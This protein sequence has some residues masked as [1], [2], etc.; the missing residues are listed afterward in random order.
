MSVL[1]TEAK[2]ASLQEALQ[3]GTVL[4]ASTGGGRYEQALLD[5]RH[6]LRADEPASVGGN[7]VGP[8]PYELLLMS[9][10]ACTSM[11][12]Q[13]Y[14]G[15]KKW[16]LEQVQVRLSHAK[17]H[18]EDCADCEKPSAMIDR[19][20]RSITLTGAL[21]DEQRARLMEIADRCP[22]HRTLTSKIV[23]VTRLAEAP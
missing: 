2:W 18:A 5:G 11:T 10:G 20:E 13:M 21:T 1:D 9:L 7:D 15:Q 6:R 16:P 19:I 23:I 17:V 4:V 22:V 12:L 3:P 14:A 8:G